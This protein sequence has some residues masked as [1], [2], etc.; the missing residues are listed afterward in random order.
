M[1][2]KTIS[3]IIGFQLIPMNCIM[4]KGKELMKM[5]GSPVYLRDLEVDKQT[6]GFLGKGLDKLKE[7][8]KQTNSEIIV[9]YYL[10][11]PIIQE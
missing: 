5:K 6:E 2:L 8:A 7:K 9:G 10:D 11:K 1:G 3:G 4:I